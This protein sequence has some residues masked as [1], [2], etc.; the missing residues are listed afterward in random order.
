MYIENF[1]YVIYVI[2]LYLYMYDLHIYCN[3]VWPQDKL[4]TI[5]ML[6]F[7]YFF[8]NVCITFFYGYFIY[9]V[10]LYPSRGCMCVIIIYF[11]TG[12]LDDNITF[13][14]GHI[15]HVLQ[16]HMRRFNMQ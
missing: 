15:C 6:R 10:N 7:Q 16:Y 8:I 5:S 11:L 12:R 3:H 4:N 2:N 13:D 9:V 1:K 14:I